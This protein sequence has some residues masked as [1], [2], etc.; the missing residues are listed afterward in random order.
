MLYICG[1][2]NRMAPDVRQAFQEVYCEHNGASPA[3]AEAWLADLRAQ[4][5]FLEDIWGGAAAPAV[6]QAASAAGTP[7]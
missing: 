7:A 5:R 6:I 3:D 4:N 2:A 1:D